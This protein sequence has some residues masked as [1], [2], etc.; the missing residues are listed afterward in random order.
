MIMA[1]K[2]LSWWEPRWAY[3][4]QLYREFKAVLFSKN[5]LYLIAISLGLFS[6]IVLAAKLAF[7]ALQL[8]FLGGVPVILVV[9]WALSWSHC[10]V[11]LAIPPVINITDKRI[12]GSHGQVGWIYKREEVTKSRIVVFANDR[13]RLR[14][15]AKGSSRVIGVAEKVGLKELKSFLPG[16]VEVWDARDRYRRE[17]AEKP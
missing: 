4:P 13:I 10:G 9:V 17:V 6:L 16:T 7:P 12:K 1:A 8:G 5:N 15:F 11:L 14:L 2:K 3:V